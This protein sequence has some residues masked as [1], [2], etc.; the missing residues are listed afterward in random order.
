MMETTKR[1]IIRTP[2]L[3][4]RNQNN[5]SLIPKT[6]L[7]AMLIFLLRRQEV[8]DPAG[9]ALHPGTC[10]ISTFRRRTA[11]RSL[12]QKLANLAKISDLIK[13]T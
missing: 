10:S 6:I 13:I 3:I 1:K 5:L 2:G 8:A 7:P 12:A 4:K 9:R 11:Q